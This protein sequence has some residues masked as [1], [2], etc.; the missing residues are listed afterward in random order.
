MDR[1]RTFSPSSRY[2]K[3]RR[4]VQTAAPKSIVTSIM[5]GIAKSRGNGIASPA[6]R[7]THHHVSQ[8]VWKLVGP[9]ETRAEEQ[10]SGQNPTRVSVHVRT[11][12]PYGTVLLYTVTV[13][14]TRY[15]LVLTVQVG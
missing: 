1:N 2:L 5:S 6:L 12:I 7:A 8:S 10:E 3:G 14:R 4:I 9:I 15:W 11:F 13:L